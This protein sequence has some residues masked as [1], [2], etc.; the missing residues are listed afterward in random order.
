MKK[1]IIAL[2]LLSLILA[3]CTG[4]LRDTDP[5]PGIEGEENNDTDPTTDDDKD[6][7]EN[8]N[9]QTDDGGAFAG[10]FVMSDSL[11]RE[12]SEYYSPYSILGEH[13]YAAVELQ[14]LPDFEDIDSIDI[15]DLIFY[16]NIMTPSEKTR[17][18]EEGYVIVPKEALE[19][20]IISLFGRLPEGFEHRSIDLYTLEGDHYKP[21]GFGIHV[22]SMYRMKEVSQEGDIYTAT[23]DVFAF[24]EDDHF[25]DPDTY[26]IEHVS[27]NMQQLIAYVN[28][29]QIVEKGYFETLIENAFVEENY[30]EIFE[31]R[32]EVTIQ[33]CYQPGSDY[34]IKYLMKQTNK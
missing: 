10:D 7:E 2:L 31:V 25:Y 14:I 8:Q 29:H 30:G 28:D 22:D 34:P 17:R 11:I 33:F 19:E 5:D 6:K 13:H 21:V 12:F 1:I 15:D 27:P 18:N 16:G 4:E 3:G 9:N 23:F 32:E 24:N 20:T 26:E